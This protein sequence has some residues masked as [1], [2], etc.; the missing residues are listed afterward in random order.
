MTEY[1]NL[2]VTDYEFF[3]VFIAFEMWNLVQKSYFLQSY[4]KNLKIVWVPY[5]DFLV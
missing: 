5:P 2:Y 1:K 3:L 4:Q